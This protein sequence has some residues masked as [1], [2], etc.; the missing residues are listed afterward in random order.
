MR[1]GFKTAPQNTTWADMLAVFQ[2]ADEMEIFE[3]GWG[4]RPLL[5]DLQRLEG[6]CDVATGTRH[7]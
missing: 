3:S 1:Y 2:A 5:P 6:A 7:I 4:V